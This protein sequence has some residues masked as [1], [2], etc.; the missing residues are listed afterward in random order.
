MFNY[1]PSRKDTKAAFLDPNHSHFLLVD[2]SRLN[3]F[4]GEISFRTELESEIAKGAGSGKSVPIVL[5]VVEGGPNT[6]VTILESIRKSVP[7]VI[8]DVI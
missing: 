5:V 6:I 8:I 4:G 1:K 2:D 3:K 7:C